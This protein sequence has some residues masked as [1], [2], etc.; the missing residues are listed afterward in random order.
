MKL[1]CG[2][3]TYGCERTFRTAWR[4]MLHEMFG[5]RYME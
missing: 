2:W 1:H 5:C 4:R 3:R